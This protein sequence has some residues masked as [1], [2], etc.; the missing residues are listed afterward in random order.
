M[1]GRS[2]RGRDQAPK[3]TRVETPTGRLRVERKAAGRPAARTPVQ[4]GRHEI[5]GASEPRDAEEPFPQRLGANALHRR[6]SRMVQPLFMP[7]ARPEPCGTS[8]QDRFPAAADGRRGTGRAGQCFFRGSRQFQPGFRFRDPL[9][10]V[11][12]PACLDGILIVARN[13]WIRTCF[14]LPSP[15]FCLAAS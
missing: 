1:D 5:Q 15:Q 10:A 3:R 6:R 14:C 13:T 9:A 11:P 2:R 4:A 8:S 12:S 7:P